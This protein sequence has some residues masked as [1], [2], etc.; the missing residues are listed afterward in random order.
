M[1]DEEQSEGELFYPGKL[2]CKKKRQLRWVV[3]ELV[4]AEQDE[5]NG[6]SEMETS[7]ICSHIITYLLNDLEWSL[8]ENIKPWARMAYGPLS[9]GPE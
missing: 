3:K 6:Q 2:R 5:G 8:R 7:V 4:L 1:S 9:H